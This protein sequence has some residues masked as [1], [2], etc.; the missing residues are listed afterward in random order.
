[1]MPIASVLRSPLGTRVVT[2]VLAATLGAGARAAEP[3]EDPARLERENRILGQKIELAKG[4]AFYLVLDPRAKRL[5]LMLKGAELRSFP[6]LAIEIG[7]PRIAFVPRGF[8]GDAT[9]RI[10]T[11][12]SLDPPRD[13]DRLE[14]QVAKETSETPAEPVIPPTA[15]E[16]YPVPE[17]YRIRFAAG[18]ALEIA[19]A[20]GGG[21]ARS[22]W[23]E[24][25]AALRVHPADAVRLRVTLAPEDAAG[26]Y[27]SLPPDTSLLVAE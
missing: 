3:A 22:W 16:A 23:E 8:A 21:S 11:A 5:S 7:E 26:L 25:S 4:D 2:C 9:G 6:V 1:M 15:E 14:M 12:G 24:G 18:L 27:R 19:P 17:R 20:G 10:W 13:R